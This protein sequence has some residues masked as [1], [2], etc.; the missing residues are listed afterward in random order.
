MLALQGKPVDRMEKNS[1]Q[2]GPNATP[3]AA[4]AALAFLVCKTWVRAVLQDSG[5]LLW[6]LV[7]VSLRWR[8]KDIAPRNPWVSRRSA[9]TCGSYQRCCGSRGADCWR[10]AAV[11][12]MN[13]VVLFLC[14]FC[15]QVFWY[16]MFCSLPASRVSRSF[17]TKLR[18]CQWTL[19]RP[20]CVQRKPGI[21]RLLDYFDSNMNV[22]VRWCK[23]T[24]ASAIPQLVAWGWRLKQPFDTFEW[25]RIFDV[26]FFGIAAHLKRNL[27]VVDPDRSLHL[28]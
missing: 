12:M 24:E 16:C 2:I 23:L 5:R 4:R 25:F 22:L 28:A 3:C 18:R 11:F 13:T 6:I 8:A 15:Q 17:E 26:F 10:S 21:A 9:L 19:D 7:H 1:E 14:C 20:G 27:Q